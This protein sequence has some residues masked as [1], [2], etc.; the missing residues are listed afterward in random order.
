M[1]SDKTIQHWEPHNL[2]AFIEHHKLDE[3]T[4]E[5]LL[6]LHDGDWYWKWWHHRCFVSMCGKLLNNKYLSAS[7][8]SDGR[9]TLTKYKYIKR[10]FDNG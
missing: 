3:F 1:I 6:K 7:Y 10:K 4:I 9:R 2:L 8:F 5:D